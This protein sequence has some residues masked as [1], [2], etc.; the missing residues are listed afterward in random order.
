MGE[1]RL[2][3]SDLDGT[4]LNPQREISTE[5][6]ELVHRLQERGI[7]FTFVTGR[8]RYAIERFSSLLSLQ[9]PVVSCNGAVI[10]HGSQILVK[11]SFPLRPLKRL[12]EQAAES[13][14]TVLYFKDDQEYALRPTAW[15]RHRRQAGREV[16]CR[17]PET[18]EWE[19]WTAEKVNIISEQKEQ[20]FAALKSELDGLK[21]FYSITVYGLSGCEIIA[22]KVNKAVGLTYLCNIYGV[23]LS[24]SLAIGDNEN[25]IEMLKA[26]KI[27]AAVANAT[28]R[29]KAAADYICKN[30][31]S[32]G[33]V[34]AVK[35][36]ILYD[37]Q[38]Q[39]VR[40]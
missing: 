22:S 8:P 11:H 29:T 4:L 1:I 21:P 16:P 6:V 24:Q 7:R 20:E 34:E 15:T 37:K 13:G 12:L 10:Y 32:Q 2:V 27:G 40:V 33:V 3:V 25:D 23:Q 35:H 39:E 5:A 38:G 17:V 28:E 18:E 9:E 14:M 36:F 30:S 31:Y 26:A 19:I